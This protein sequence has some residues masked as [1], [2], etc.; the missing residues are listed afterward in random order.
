MN[1][2]QRL[3]QTSAVDTVFSEFK[4]LADT[5][6]AFKTHNQISLKSRPGAENPFMD[7]IGSLYNRNMYGNQQPEGAFTEWNLPLDNYTRQQIEQLAREQNF[8]V[9]RARFMRLNPKTGL[10]VHSD[11]TVRY[12]LVLQTNPRSYFAHNT[13]EHSTDPAVPSVEGRFYHLPADGHWYRVDTTQVH[14]VY[15]GG[16]TERVHLVI[17]QAE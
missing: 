7:G 14:W 15:N 13:L 16:T 3:T 2:I 6:P 9:G 11:T 5:L 12:H 10:S 17:S 4:N 8:V 1:F